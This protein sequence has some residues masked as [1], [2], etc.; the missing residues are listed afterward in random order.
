MAIAVRARLC[1]EHLF[2]SSFESSLV[3]TPVDVL[4]FDPFERTGN[5]GDPHQIPVELP[6]RSEE[7]ERGQSTDDE[8]GTTGRDDERTPITDEQDQHRSEDGDKAEKREGDTEK[9]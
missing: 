7:D 2:E 3:D 9:H 1:R 6:R 5:G 8:P 4:C